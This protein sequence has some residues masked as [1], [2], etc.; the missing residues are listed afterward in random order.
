MP[1]LLESD[2][3]L[4]KLTAPTHILRAIEVNMLRSVIFSE[5]NSFDPNPDE[6]LYGVSVFFSIKLRIT[7]DVGMLAAMAGALHEL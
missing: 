4:K 2:L 3:F 6:S 7:L 5:N 1:S